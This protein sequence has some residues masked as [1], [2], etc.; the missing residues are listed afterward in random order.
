MFLK[1]TIDGVLLNNFFPLFSSLNKIL[2]FKAQI[3]CE[4]CENIYKTN[5]G[6]QR[7]TKAK[8]PQKAL[9][10]ALKKQEELD[11][12]AADRLYPLYTKR[13]VNEASLKLSKDD[14]YPESVRE[15]FKGFSITSDEAHSIFVTYKELILKFKNNPEQFLSSFNIRSQDSNT[16]NVLKQRLDGY[17]LQFDYFGGI[18]Y[19]FE[20]FNGQG[21]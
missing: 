18:T 20:T 7:H 17:Q 2:L 8:H 16:V 15:K 19:A 1:S 9:Q 4:E 10:L 3:R 11:Q 5:G 13:Y 12:E 14:L 21:R 6:L